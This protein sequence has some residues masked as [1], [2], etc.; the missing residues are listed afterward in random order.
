M[1]A[2]NVVLGLVTGNFVRMRAAWKLLT[3]TM[4]TNPIGMIAV[5]ATA[6][7]TGIVKLVKWL[8]RTSDATNA[9]RDA[10]KQYVSE[11]VSEQ[12]EAMHLFNAYKKL[13]RKAKLIFKSGKRLFQS[14]AIF[15][16]INR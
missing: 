1:L 6:A 3:A 8:N 15:A 16:R 5:A 10:T 13:I 9:V 14:T 12:R 4:A 11:L 7:V 2:Y